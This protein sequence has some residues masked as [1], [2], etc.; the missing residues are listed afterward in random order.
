MSTLVFYVSFLTATLLLANLLFRWIEGVGFIG[1]ILLTRRVQKVI[2]N[3]V[4]EGYRILRVSYSSIPSIA[5]GGV[6][7]FNINIFDESNFTSGIRVAILDSHQNR[8]VTD[9]PS[10]ISKDEDDETTIDLALMRDQ[11]IES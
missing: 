11:G 1:Q 2:K 8:L 5:R 10:F 6:H 4:P 7:C 3:L 9:L